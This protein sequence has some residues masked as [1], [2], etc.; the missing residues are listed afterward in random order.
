MAIRTPSATQR[1]RL[2][3]IRITLDRQLGVDAA[4]SHYTLAVDSVGVVPI[5]TTQL[6][7]SAVP[8]EVEAGGHGAEDD[9]EG[10][11]L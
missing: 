7:T 5:T 10:M 3:M 11:Y 8:M 2:H 9:D 4:N 1:E 6:G